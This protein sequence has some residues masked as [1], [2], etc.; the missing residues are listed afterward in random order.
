MWVSADD[1]TVGCVMQHRSEHEIRN[2]KVSIVTFERKLDDDKNVTLTVEYH[3]LSTRR[4]RGVGAVW[5][6]GV[7]AVWAREVGAVWA[8]GVGAVWARCGRGVGA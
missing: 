3:K 6:R 4:V 5:A 1:T 2:H 7:G 8:R